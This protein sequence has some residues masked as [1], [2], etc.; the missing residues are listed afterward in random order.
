MTTSFAHERRALLAWINRIS[1]PA[2]IGSREQDVLVVEQSALKLYALAHERSHLIMAIFNELRECSEALNAQL[3]L[4]SSAFRDR[5]WDLAVFEESLPLAPESIPAWPLTTTSVRLCEASRGIAR[6]ANHYLAKRGWLYP[7]QLAAVC[8][9]PLVR[10]RHE[11]HW[12]DVI[13]QILQLSSHEVWTSL[14]SQQVH[15]QGDAAVP[16]EIESTPSVPAARQTEMLAGPPTDAST[17]CG[18]R[19]DEHFVPAQ[20][21]AVPASLDYPRMSTNRTVRCPMCEFPISVTSLPKHREQHTRSNGC[22]RVRYCCPS[23][24]FRGDAMYQLTSHGRLYPVTPSKTTFSRNDFFNEVA[25]QDKRCNGKEPQAGIQVLSNTN[26]V[27]FSGAIQNPS[28]DAGVHMKPEVEDESPTHADAQCTVGD[29]VLVE[30]C[31]S[32]S[33]NVEFARKKRRGV[34]QDPSQVR[35]HA[36]Q[37]KDEAAVSSQTLA[38]VEIE[39]IFNN[40][41]CVNSEPSANID[42]SASVTAAADTE[43]VPSENLEV[44]PE[45]NS[46]GTV[47][48]GAT[49]DVEVGL[50]VNRAT[51]VEHE[52]LD[53]LNI[54][55]AVNDGADAEAEPHSGFAP[56]PRPDSDPKVK[57]STDYLWIAGVEKLPRYPCGLD[58]CDFVCSASNLK[59]MREHIHSAHCS[60]APAMAEEQWLWRVKAA[61]ETG[62]LAP[63][64]AKPRK[65]GRRPC[66]VCGKLFTWISRPMA[67]H[68]TSRYSCP[69]CS[70]TRAVFSQLPSH[71]RRRHSGSLPVSPLGSRDTIPTTASGLTSSANLSRSLALHGRQRGAPVSGSDGETQSKMQPSGIPAQIS[72]NTPSQ[73]QTDPFGIPSRNPSSAFIAPVHQTPDDRSVHHAD[74]GSHALTVDDAFQ[75]DAPRTSALLDRLCDGAGAAHDEGDGLMAEESQ[76]EHLEHSSPDEPPAPHTMSATN[77]ALSQEVGPDEVPSILPSTA[78]VATAPRP[79]QAEGM[80]PQADMPPRSASMEC[81]SINETLEK[82]DAVGTLQV[83]NKPLI[84]AVQLQSE[85][86]SEGAGPG[87]DSGEA[88]VTEKSTGAMVATGATNS[89]K[90]MEFSDAQEK[91]KAADIPEVR[92]VQAGFEGHAATQGPELSSPASFG[93]DNRAMP[94]MQ[95]CAQQSPH[96]IFKTHLASLQNPLAKNVRSASVLEDRSSI[97][98]SWPSTCSQ[99]ADVGDSAEH[100]SKINDQQV[101]A[102]VLACT[103]IEEPGTHEGESFDDTTADV[104]KNAL[105]HVADATGVRPKRKKIHLARK[106]LRS[107]NKLSV[108][109]Q[110][111]VV[112]SSPAVPSA[113]SA[114]DVRDIIS[115]QIQT[116]SNVQHVPQ[117][118]LPRRTYKGRGKLTCAE[119]P[120]RGGCGSSQQC[121]RS[122]TQ[123]GSHWTK[124]MRLQEA[125]ETTS[126]HVQKP[127]E[128]LQDPV[129]SGSEASLCYC[130]RGEE[131]EVRVGLPL[132]S[133]SMRASAR[134]RH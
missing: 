84:L 89:Q 82:A 6:S 22:A 28:P 27:S 18:Q 1:H 14:G 19:A 23:C 25:E 54:G 99:L 73:G 55:P 110:P 117:H 85:L 69:R 17:L 62:E 111:P 33:P 32:N 49:A 56:S 21:P 96:G 78:I 41:A 60:I 4:A 105:P 120:W 42:A 128:P 108:P 93:P 116:T 7:V 104:R 16:R 47:K 38:A 39:P 52:L 127:F 43:Q 40:V 24:R 31:P 51:V 10:V 57:N 92:K 8:P 129:E 65:G 88:A 36:P 75:L 87:T 74:V 37:A 114:M 86:Q 98:Q 72:L 15:S 109:T 134:N 107:K 125:T 130:G 113:P 97:A 70:Y 126:V 45:A 61:M 103:D 34:E 9:D 118:G 46:G 80:K 26:P 132:A 59:A 90:V 79:P 121:K 115:L 102:S 122:Q 11:L 119:P 29:G 5:Q 95:D 48:H 63:S 112:P 30:C 44:E 53:N 68:D 133:G 50:V 3:I 66:P 131:G 124:R 64:H 2:H 81:V 71:W 58:G 76:S 100:S 106:A 91:V 83:Q 94:V 101:G 35:D 20:T 12:I 13:A 67:V 123:A 77:A